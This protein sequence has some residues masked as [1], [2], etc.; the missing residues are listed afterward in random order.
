MPRRAR[1]GGASPDLARGIGVAQE[2]AEHSPLER[3]VAPRPQA[4]AVER[5]RAEPAGTPAV[6]DQ[7]DERRSDALADPVLQE[8]RVAEDG[9]A[10]QGAE[11]GAQD[12][13][14]GLGVEDHRHLGGRHLARAQAAE[15]A[16]GG[17]PAHLLGR[18]QLREPATHRVP[19]VAL[20]LSVLLG[21]RRHRE[22][23]RGGAVAPHEAEGVG[24]EHE[25]L[26]R[27]PRRALRVRDAGDGEGRGLGSSRAVDALGRRE[28]GHRR[29]VEPE[30]D[31]LGRRRLV[32]QAGRGVLTGD[33]GHGDGLADECVEG[34][35]REVR[36]VGGCGTAA[37]EH[38]K[39]Q[40]LAPRVLQGLDLALADGDRELGPFADDQ[41][42]PVCPGAARR[43][44]Q[45]VGEIAI[46]H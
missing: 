5:P 4:L 13:G 26:A 15:R 7:G 3:H 19:V 6:V 10:R 1:S 35:L 46:V 16:F 8:R 24:Q 21:L 11:Y 29:V 37:H 25:A 20:H 17:F 41:V 27:A 39:A 45:V 38:A 31:V 28:R 33:P 40:G 36:R 18:V 34:G 12:L 32:G 2:V 14:R 42:G 22:R 43:L 9:V 44:E 30:V 23:G